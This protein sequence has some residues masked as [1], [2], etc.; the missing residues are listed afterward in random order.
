[1]SSEIALTAAGRVPNTVL[2][3]KQELVAQAV[4]RGLDDHAAGIAAGFKNTKWLRGNINRLRHTP[5]MQ[6]RIRE[7]LNGAAERAEL[8]VRWV[9]EELRQFAGSSLATFWA[10]DEN[11]KIIF[12]N[13]KPSLDLSH[14]TPE[15]LRC[16]EEYFVDNKGAVKL[17]VID[18]LAA[19]DKLARHLG[20]YKDAAG[21]TAVM[22]N[23]GPIEF[24][25]V[26]PEQAEVG[27]GDRPAAGR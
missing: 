2:P 20:M 25:L 13:G 1:M 27:D 12:R 4:A 15:Q 11:N 5:I 16:I 19:L 26:R 3:L 10:R 6:E 9:Y 8:E 24:R 21:G 23:N 22:I 18:R 14:A 17:K 7:L